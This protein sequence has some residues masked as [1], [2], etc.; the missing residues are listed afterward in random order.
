MV[1]CVFV[2]SLLVVAKEKPSRDIRTIKLIVY[3]LTDS[4]RNWFRSLISEVSFKLLDMEGHR[5]LTPRSI[6]LVSDCADLMGLIANFLPPKE[7]IFAFALVSKT[8]HSVVKREKIALSSSLRLYCRSLSSVLWLVSMG[9]ED[10]LRE[11]LCTYAAGNGDMSVLIWACSQKPAWS[12][13]QNTC[14][15]AASGGHIEI[16]QWLRVQDP[17]APWD[18]KSGHVHMLLST[19]I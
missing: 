18:E 10:R 12:C 3:Q 2:L 11:K 19:V 8:C 6:V 4:S 5:D 1:S 15:V 14:A 13:D 9:L 7:N 17:P 16:L